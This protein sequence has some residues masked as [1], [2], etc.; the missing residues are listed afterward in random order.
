MLIPFLGTN[1]CCYPK[2]AQSTLAAIDGQ[3]RYRCLAGSSGSGSN[4]KGDARRSAHSLDWL[5]HGKKACAEN[6]QMKNCKESAGI[7]H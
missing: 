2:V 5:Q 3:R 1:L 4:G 6:T 7:N